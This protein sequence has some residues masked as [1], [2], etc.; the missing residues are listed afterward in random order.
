MTHRHETLLKL[1]AGVLVAVVPASL[2]YCQARSVAQEEATQMTRESVAGYKA[3]VASVRRLEEVVALQGQALTYVM[4]VRPAAAGSGSGSGDASGS[5]AG[6]ELP[7]PAF[8]R[9]PDSPAAA[10]RQ[11][12][13]P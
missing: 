4:Q 12:A 8:E 2:S 13:L 11:Q 9:L 7:A 3:L 5:G 10:L 1:L 6:P